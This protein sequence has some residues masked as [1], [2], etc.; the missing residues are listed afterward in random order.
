MS[1]PGWN[2]QNEAELRRLWNDGYSASAIADRFSETY[3]VR[4]TRNTVGGKA[5]RLGLLGNRQVRVSGRLREKFERP[6]R[7]TTQASSAIQDEGSEKESIA[8]KPVKQLK[9]GSTKTKTELYA[10]LA[11]A[12]RNTK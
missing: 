12:V 2:E 3:G 1:W 11:E 10:M 8:V 6:S 9:S 5:H 4:I 7:K